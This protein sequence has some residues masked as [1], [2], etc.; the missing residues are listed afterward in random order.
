ML[1]LKFGIIRIKS[2]MRWVG[3]VERTGEM[4]AKFCLESLKGRDHSEV[5]CLDGSTD[6]RDGG[7]KDAEMVNLAQGG[8]RWRALVNT[9]MNLLVP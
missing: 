9:I 4:R 7:L 6:R 1:E 8:C 3:N 5:L 2:R